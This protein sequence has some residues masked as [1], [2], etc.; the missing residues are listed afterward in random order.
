MQ[1]PTSRN[2]WISS[3][4]GGISKRRIRTT[5][6]STSNRNYFLGFSLSVDDMLWKDALDAIMYLRQLM[7]EKLKE[8]ISDIR[9]WVN[10]Q[11][12]IAVARSYSHMICGARLPSPLRDWYIYFELGSFLVLAQYILVQNNLVRTSAQNV[13]PPT[14]ARPPPSPRIAHVPLLATD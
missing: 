11:I 14:W 10:G 3:W 13:S 4:I 1:T 2:L 7:A 12:V 5:S 6:T 8:P 9:G